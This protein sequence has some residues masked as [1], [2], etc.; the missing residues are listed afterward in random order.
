M[1][2]RNP[3]KDGPEYLVVYLSEGGAWGG[4][5]ATLGTALNV[6]CDRLGLHDPTPKGER[7]VEHLGVET[8][9]WDF[10]FDGGVVVRIVEE[11]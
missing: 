8:R 1:S 2:K 4:H 6:A 3:T 9:A 5:Y 7:K 11:H 10:G